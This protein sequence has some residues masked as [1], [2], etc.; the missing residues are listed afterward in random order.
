MAC[1]RNI[2]AAESQLIEGLLDRHIRHRQPK[3]REFE[4]VL[5][6]VVRHT[7]YLALYN[8]TSSYWIPT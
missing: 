7:R 6:L 5:A 2:L 8:T 1:S 4:R 3:H